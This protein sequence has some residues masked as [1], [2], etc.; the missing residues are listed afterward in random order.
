MSGWKF[1]A[2]LLTNH[3][4]LLFKAWLGAEPF[5]VCAKKAHKS[6]A[7]PS[8]V[9]VLV[10]SWKV[11]ENEWKWYSWE[12]RI[13]MSIISRPDFMVKVNKV[14]EKFTDI[15]WLRRISK[16]QREAKVLAR[17]T[18]FWISFH[19]TFINLPL[20]FIALLSGVDRI[21]SYSVEYCLGG[22]EGEEELSS[23]LS[24]INYNISVYNVSLQCWRV[25]DHLLK[26]SVPTTSPRSL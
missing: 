12:Q 11:M 10:L 15:F 1:G 22:G 23:T 3:K 14:S 20:S 4:F 16:L 8:P 24:Q 21:V 13:N 18:T 17:F 7:R 25:D 5:W 19:I 26:R 9:S 6:C 2:F